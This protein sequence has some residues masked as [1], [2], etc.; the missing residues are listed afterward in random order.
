MLDDHVPDGTRAA[1]RVLRHLLLQ[2]REYRTQWQRYQ[3]RRS[4]ADVI[5][6][7]AIAMVITHY[8]MDSGLFPESE[9]RLD[10]KLKDRVGRALEGKVLSPETLNW[11]IEAFC[12]TPEDE[13]MLRESYTTARIIAH[14]PVAN[15]LRV[16]Q[17][18]PVPQRHRTV[19]LFERRIIGVTGR[20]VTHHS[21]HT[22]VACEDDVGHYPCFRSARTTDIVMV[23]GGYIS[24]VPDLAVDP[25]IVN[26]RLSAFLRE[27]ESTSFEYRR[28]FHREGGVDTEYRRAANA[29]TQ[30]IDI[31]VQ[32]HPRR[33]PD[34]VWWAA[35]DDYRDGNV[36]EREAVA[37][38]SENRAH[39]FLP[40]L[41]NA[42]A[43]FCWAW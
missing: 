35:W 12:L 28:D 7:H 14:G 8:L 36:V 19:M 1:G 11:F 3:Q 23:H 4:P 18:L 9:T 33:L 5:N 31:V 40:Y 27:G 24:P 39:R 30:N 22:I 6:K 26:I 2:R 41:E 32:F 37:L 43:G 13:Q 25:S 38:D 17:N 21:A 42:V 15:T 16:R 29:R 34:K 10:R 20:A